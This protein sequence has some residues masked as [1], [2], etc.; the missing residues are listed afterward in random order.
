MVSCP[1]RYKIPQQ[2]LI[3]NLLALAVIEL[4]DNETDSLGS[5][6]PQATVVAG[7]APP[8]TPKSEFEVIKLSSLFPLLQASFIISLL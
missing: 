4:P 8:V 5:A 7:S 2:N 6:T 1:K 3:N